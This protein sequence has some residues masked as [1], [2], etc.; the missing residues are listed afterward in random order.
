MIKTLHPLFSNEPVLNSQTE[1]TP[2]MPFQI[3]YDE[4]FLKEHS[5]FMQLH[6]HLHLKRL[7]F[8]ISSLNS[9]P[10]NLKKSR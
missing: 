10:E 4:S 9:K 5:F 1:I 8:T 7:K 3:K 6:F 2:V